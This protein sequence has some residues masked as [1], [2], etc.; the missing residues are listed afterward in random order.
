MTGDWLR[1][2]PSV[3]ASILTAIRDVLALTHHWAAIPISSPP[4]EFHQQS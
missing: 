2:K 3:A 4:Y 1:A